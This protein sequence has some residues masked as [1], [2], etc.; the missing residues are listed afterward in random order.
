MAE[1]LIGGGRTCG[2]ALSLQRTR[3]RRAS[4]H[5]NEAWN[6][7]GIRALRGLRLRGRGRGEEGGP[8]ALARS[9]PQNGHART[10]V[11]K[12][13]S[14]LAFFLGRSDLPPPT[15]FLVNFLPFPPHPQKR[16]L[17]FSFNGGHFPPTPPPLSPPPLPP[18]RLSS[19]LPLFPY[20]IYR[21]ARGGG[22]FSFLLRGCVHAV[23]L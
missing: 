12:N 7:S 16:P 17:A 1:A 14:I 4:A 2:S 3:P 8:G 10:P 22:W 23:G 6:V 20:A 18:R 15:K 21:N 9:G 19:F 13:V 11:W 5:A